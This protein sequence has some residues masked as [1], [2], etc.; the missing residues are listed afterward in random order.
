MHAPPPRVKIYTK[1]V[2]FHEGFYSMVGLYYYDTKR[3]SAS[4]C[5]FS[6]EDL[7]SIIVRVTNIHTTLRTDGNCIWIVKLSIILPLLA[8]RPDVLAARLD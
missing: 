6:F 7:N 3:Q 5:S 4:D 1:K 2:C 8:K